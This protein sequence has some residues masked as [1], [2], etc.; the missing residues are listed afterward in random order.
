[1]RQQSLPPLTLYFA[2]SLVFVTPCKLHAQPSRVA[3]DET[4]DPTAAFEFAEWFDC[5]IRPPRR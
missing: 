4:T 3:F 5:P 2:V 1:M